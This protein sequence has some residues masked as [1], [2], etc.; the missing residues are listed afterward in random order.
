MTSWC[1]RAPAGTRIDGMPFKVMAVGGRRDHAGGQRHQRR[2]D[3]HQPADGA[4]S[5]R[6]RSWS[7][8]AP[9]SPP[10]TRPAPPSTSPRCATSRIASSPACRP[11]ARG[12]PP[13]SMTATTP[14]WCARATTTAR[15]RT[16]VID[17]RLPDGC[18]W[19]FAAIVNTFDVTLG[20]N[21]AVD[22]HAGRPDRRAGALLQDAAARLRG[23]RSAA[24]SRAAPRPRNQRAAAGRA[25]SGGA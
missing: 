1:R 8:A 9:T 18:G 5:A 2:G 16:A 11:S 3:R 20:I 7:C 13:A 14:R 6:R 10:T 23:A 12:P 19:T 24:P 4:R 17:V 22:Q 21:A 15:A 25:A